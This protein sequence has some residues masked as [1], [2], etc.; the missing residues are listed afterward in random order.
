[1]SALDV[2]IRA[3][4]QLTSTSILKFFEIRMAFLDNSGRMERHVAHSMHEFENSKLS[5][6]L[7]MS[8]RTVKLQPRL[9]KWLMESEL[10]SSL[11]QLVI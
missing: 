9:T 5:T 2:K 7:R 3:I 6:N 8:T 4:W 1:M 11:S 10:G